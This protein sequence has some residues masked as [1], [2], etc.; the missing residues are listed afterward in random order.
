[1]GIAAVAAGHIFGRGLHG[2]QA[3]IAIALVIYPLVTSCA[4]CAAILV[5]GHHRALAGAGAGLGALV[6]SMST[7]SYDSPGDVLIFLVV[8]GP[9][10]ALSILAGAIGAWL[11]ILCWRRLRA[12]Q[13]TDAER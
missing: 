9:I 10:L 5:F 2:A 1:M 7:G 13:S 11:L 6:A 8:I 12:R 3:G 4:C